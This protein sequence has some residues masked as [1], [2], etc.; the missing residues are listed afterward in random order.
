VDYLTATDNLSSFSHSNSCTSSSEWY[1]IA[2]VLN[3]QLRSLTSFESVLSSDR[4]AEC[5]LLRPPAH[6][7]AV[8]GVVNAMVC[9]R[10]PGGVRDL[11]RTADG[12]NASTVVTACHDDAV[13]AM[14]TAK[15]LRKRRGAIIDSMLPSLCTFATSQPE[16]QKSLCSKNKVHANSKHP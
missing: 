6:Q 16:P 15:P 1:A 11:R 4:V 10:W 12:T 5:C 8:F 13:A 14:A 9:S 2:A 7:G 3:G